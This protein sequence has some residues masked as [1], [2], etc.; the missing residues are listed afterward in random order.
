MTFLLLT[1]CTL[2]IAQSAWRFGTASTDV[3]PGYPVRLSGYAVR[4]T[5][6]EGVDMPLFV[7]A[8]ALEERP[9]SVALILTIDNCGISRSIRNEITARI[10]RRNPLPPERVVIF[11]SHT[12][13]APA[14]T[15]AIPNMF[16][17]PLPP[18]DAATVDRYT[19]ELI[20]KVVA[21]ART[22][23]DNLETGSLFFAQG[24]VSFAKNRRTPGGPVDH[25]VP[26]LAVKDAQGKVRAALANYACHCTTLQGDL[27]RIHGD[28]V[29]VAAKILEEKNPGMTALFS[30]GCG[31]DSNPAP[32][33]KIEHVNAHGQELANEVARLLDSPLQEMNGRLQFRS[34]AIELPFDPLPSREEWE[35]RAAQPGIVGYH[36]KRN[37]ERLD[38]GEKLPV[39]LPYLVQTWNFGDELAMV[40]LPGEVVVD[41]VLR[42]KSIYNPERLWVSAY[43]NW[44][45]CYIPSERIL[46]EGGYEAESSLWYYDRPARLSPKTEELIIS[47]VRELLPKT[48]MREKTSAGK[49]K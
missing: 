36:A 38:R 42:L 16:A 33:G 25:A 11:S 13:S 41:Y 17:G 14:L 27:N 43:A 1:H 22:A 35:K 49:E 8:L 23:L 3:T 19:R 4:Q 26:V 7:K 6:S 12:H 29:G 28:W 34:K 5:V 20:D 2:I 47:T 40:F 18:E 46:R 24:K 44:V 48:F 9:G 37:L 10:E 45:P 15:G 30:I 32:R 31:A 21:T 39:A